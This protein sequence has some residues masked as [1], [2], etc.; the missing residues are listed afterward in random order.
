MSE[1]KFMIRNAEETDAERLVEIYAYYVESTA[2]SFE[3]KVP[4]VS[5]FKERIRNTCSFG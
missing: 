1:E 3:Y 2:V 5:E 4:T